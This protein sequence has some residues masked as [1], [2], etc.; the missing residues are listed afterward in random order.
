MHYCVAAQTQSDFPGYKEKMTQYSEWAEEGLVATKDSVPIR[1]INFVQ[2]LNNDCVLKRH[3]E[4]SVEFKELV[5]KNMNRDIVGYWASSNR[6]RLEVLGLLAHHTEFGVLLRK[7]LTQGH[8]PFEFTY[9]DAKGAT[10]K[11]PDNPLRGWSEAIRTKYEAQ[12]VAACHLDRVKPTPD[13]FLAKEK[14]FVTTFYMFEPT[15]RDIFI[16]KSIHPHVRI[17]AIVVPRPG[18]IDQREIDAILAAKEEAKG[19]K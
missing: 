6:L 18:G 10:S 9:D 19:K 16:C 12:T 3:W 4:H 15:P 2:L 13:Q 14:L 5:M 7:E 11:N 1:L 8:P 17:V